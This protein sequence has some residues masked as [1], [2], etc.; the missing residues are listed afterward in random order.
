M[1]KKWYYLKPRVLK[2]LFCRHSLRGIGHQ[3]LLY[4]VFGVS[5]DVVEKVG[6]ELEIS[7]E[8][9]ISERHVLRPLL[10]EG[11]AAR[12]HLVEEDSQGPAVHLQGVVMAAPLRLIDLRS[13]VLPELRYL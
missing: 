7:G 2:D 4:H 5:R 3:Q 11:R 10:G 13:H 1:V 9:L 12:D 6:V 8:N